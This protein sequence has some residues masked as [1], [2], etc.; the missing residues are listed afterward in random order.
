MMAATAR[1]NVSYWKWTL[2]GSLCSIEADCICLGVVNLSFV[3]YSITRTGTSI[4]PMPRDK[5]LSA[6]VAA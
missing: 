2:H 1:L 3:K 6:K 5:V 4:L